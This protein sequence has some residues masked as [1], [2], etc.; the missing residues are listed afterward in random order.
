LSNNIRVTVCQFQSKSPIHTPISSK[1]SFTGFNL[2]ADFSATNRLEVPSLLLIRCTSL[3]P[4]Q[5][6]LG[7]NPY[8][9]NI[10]CKTTRKGGPKFCDTN[11]RTKE[12]A[13]YNQ[14]KKTVTD[15][16]Q[17]HTVPHHKHRTKANRTHNNYTNPQ[18]TSIQHQSNHKHHKLHKSSRIKRKGGRINGSINTKSKQY[19]AIQ[20]SES[21]GSNFFSC[22]RRSRAVCLL[23]GIFGFRIE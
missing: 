16:N 13:S 8:P 4:L 7:L 12:P 17:T 23:F 22:F 15:I 1:P 2:Q 18:T 19:K 6:T 10:T 11:F 21:K 3:C 20:T 14:S 9:I 5:Q